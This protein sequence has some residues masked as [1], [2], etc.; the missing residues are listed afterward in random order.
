M[1]TSFTCLLFIHL[2]ILHFAFLFVYIYLIVFL[3]LGHIFL[4][5][6]ERFFFK[7]GM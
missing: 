1:F 2:F 5:L 7:D 4:T 3:L 6:R